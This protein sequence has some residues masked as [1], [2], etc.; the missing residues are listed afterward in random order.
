[1][2]GILVLS[3]PS[4]VNYEETK[5]QVKVLDEQLCLHLDH[6]KNLPLII[7]ADD[8]GFVAST[9]NNFLWV[10]FTRCNPS[11]DM[12][13]ISAFTENNHWG[14]K[15]PLVIDARRKPHH[16][17]LVEKDASVERSLDKFF[18]KGASLYNKIA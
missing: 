9:L 1:M 17:P 18:N 3:S 5:K 7:L 2:P 6:L 13:G 4:F 11:H 15:G 12:Y 8:A 16:A 14:C 10:T